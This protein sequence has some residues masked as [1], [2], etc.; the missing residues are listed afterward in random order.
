MKMPYLKPFLFDSLVL[1]LPTFK[2]RPA[3][4]D[5]FRRKDVNHYCMCVNGFSIVLDITLAPPSSCFG[6][7]NG[8]TY[9]F[10]C[11]Y[12]NISGDAYALSP[13]QETQLLNVI[14]LNLLISPAH[15]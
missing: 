8:I 1:F 11:V 4:A 15:A 12:S 14:K 9:L 13:E 2:V 5:Y 3:S 7:E 10:A 6:G